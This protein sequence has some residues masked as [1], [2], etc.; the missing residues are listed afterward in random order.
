E[1]PR[2]AVVPN[3]IDVLKQSNL[4]SFKTRRFGFAMDGKTK[5]LCRTLFIKFFTF[6]VRCVKKIIDLLKK[7]YT[8]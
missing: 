6:F 7:R 4:Q 3:R 8:S 5:P 2:M 1:P